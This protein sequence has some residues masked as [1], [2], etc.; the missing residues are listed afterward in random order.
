MM[1]T[2]NQLH[3]TSTPSS[4]PLGEL[5]FDSIKVNYPHLFEG[6]GE[7]GEP[8]SLTL[9]PTIKPI[10]AAPHRYAGYQTWWYVNVHHQ[11]LSLPKFAFV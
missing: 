3:V 11:Q 5:T 10:Q 6:L 9:D 1:W 8:Y 4:P 7:L 2:L